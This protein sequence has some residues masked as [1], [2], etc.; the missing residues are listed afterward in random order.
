MNPRCAVSLDNQLDLSRR[1]GLW[2]RT[3]GHGLAFERTQRLVMAAASFQL[4]FDHHDAV[5]LLVANKQPASGL[6]LLRPLYE[7]YVLGLWLFRI[8][9]QQQIDAM[10]AR[11]LAPELDRMVRNL[12]GKK[13]FDR[14]MLQDMKTVIKKMHG[15]T[16][17]GVEHIQYRY[18]DGNISPNY[19]DELMVDVLQIADLFT[20]MAILESAALA[21]DI[22]LG[23]R[24]SQE[25]RE[26]L[27]FSGAQ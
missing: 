21:E 25:G 7:S 10:L 24:L 23:D 19:P 4:T 20:V 8:A 17:G 14:P 3:N 11:R 2:V 6:A 5:V 18:A 27:G 22:T 1:L 9:D 13:F 16:H 26:L 15:F 12:D